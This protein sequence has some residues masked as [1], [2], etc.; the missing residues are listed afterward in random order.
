MVSIIYCREYENN[1]GRTVH[2]A[3]RKRE[4]RTDSIQ[5]ACKR[6]FAERQDNSYQIIGVKVW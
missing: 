5:A 2:D 3:P 4:Y 1:K 6:F